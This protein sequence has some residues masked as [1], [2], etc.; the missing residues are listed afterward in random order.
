MNL[1]ENHSKVS[2]MKYED[3]IEQLRNHNIIYVTG[4]QRSG[5][6]ITSRIISSDLQMKC[7]DEFEFG[8][9]DLNKLSELIAKSSSAVIQCPCFFHALDRLYNISPDA[10]L[11]VMF[12]DI[13]DIK[14]SQDRI[15]WCEDLDKKMID[16]ENDPRTVSEIDYE[17]Y[18]KQRPLLKFPKIL[19]IEYDSLISHELYVHKEDRKKFTP[20]QWRKT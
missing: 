16:A 8:V 20:K 15:N 5:T 7:I 18:I 10:A 11:V 12:R 6:T 2:T 3:A 4:P 13:E 19:N 9:T 1:V 14:A 17:N